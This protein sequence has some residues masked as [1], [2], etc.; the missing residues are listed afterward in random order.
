MNKGIVED[1]W[2]QFKGSVQKN[3]GKLANDDLYE[4]RQ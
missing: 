4:N 1:K 3:W 2:K